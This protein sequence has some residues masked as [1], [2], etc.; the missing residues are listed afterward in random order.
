LAELEI[1][2][3]SFSYRTQDVFSDIS[4]EVDRGQLLSLV[5]PN[6]TGKTT[7]MKCINRLHQQQSGQILVEGKNVSSYARMDLAR[8]VAYV[9]QSE[10]AKFPISVFDAVLIGRRPHMSWRATQEDL[11]MV[12]DILVKMEIADLAGKALNALSGGE[13]QKVMIAKA[14]VQEPDVLLLDEP[15]TFLDMGYQ[16]RIMQYVRE[17]VDEHKIC[18]VMATHELNY[19]LQYSDKIAVMKDHHM[20]AYGAPDIITEDVIRKVYGIDSAIRR[21]NG[22]PYIVP[23]RAVD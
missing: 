1:S 17:L 19:A 16:L 8:K 5:G 18:A 13:R 10:N 23:L 22:H 9:P 12:F 6:G 3:L 21:E 14:I 4:F 2:G 7:L 15:T 20:L 11:D